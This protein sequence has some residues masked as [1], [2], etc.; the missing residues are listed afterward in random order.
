MGKPRDVCTQEG[1][2]G[3]VGRAHTSVFPLSWGFVPVFGGTVWKPAANLISFA[4]PV[5][6]HPFPAKF[7]PEAN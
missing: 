1:I 4:K 2:K 6:G 3:Q 7:L 5:S